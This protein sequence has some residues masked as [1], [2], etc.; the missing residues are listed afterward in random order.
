MLKATLQNFLLSDSF[1]ESTYNG[2]KKSKHLETRKKVLEF[3]LLKSIP[4]IMTLNLTSHFMRA[5]ILSCPGNM[6]LPRLRF[7]KPVITT[8]FK[9]TVYMLPK[10]EEIGSEI[11]N[12]LFKSKEL[13]K[14]CRASFE[15]KN[16]L[17]TILLILKMFIVNIT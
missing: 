17:N 2:L 9:E 8:T 5:I 13:L 4:K 12:H 6:S 3:K 11:L 15:T 10:D 1:W 14:I 7:E 16:S